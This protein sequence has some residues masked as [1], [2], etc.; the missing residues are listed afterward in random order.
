MMDRRRLVL[1]TAEV[2]RIFCVLMLAP[3]PIAFAYET[4]DLNVLGFLVP[5]NA[6]IFLATALIGALYWA[7]VRAATRGVEDQELQDREAY[8]V[9][10]IGW[11]LLTLLALIPFLWS[12]VT[13]SFGDAWFEAMSGLTT[14][15]ATILST[16]LEQVPKSIM[17]WR[18]QLEY[19][20][21]MGII[22]LSVAVL[23]R[24]T[25]GGTQLLQAEAPG[26]SVTRL[27]PKL[28]QTAKALWTVYG[29]ISALLLVI[30]TMIFLGEGLIW[31]DALYDAL[32]HTFTTVS[33]GGFSNH[34]ASIGYYDSWLLEATIILFMLIAGSN[35]TLH[36]YTLHGDWR[37]L[38]RDREWRFFMLTFIGVTLTATGMLW[39]AGQDV[40][41]GFRGAAFTVASV[42]SGTGFVAVDFNGWPEILKV[43]LLVLMITGATAGSTTG[44]LKMVRIMI[45]LKIVVREIRKL[46]HPRAV[47]PIRLGG[48]VLRDETL[49]TTVAFFFSFVTIWMVGAMLLVT[50]EPGLDVFDGA[51]IA[52]SA[53]SNFGPSMGVIGPLD[54]YGAL[55]YGSKFTMTVLM[56]A[57][58]LE[59]FT[60][61]LLFSPAAWRK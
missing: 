42:S 43:M 55:S 61:M 13:G 31:K 20:G 35:F 6:M 56:W 41:G 19:I 3:I 34:G 10:G 30:L 2:V 50:M 16:D 45:L 17:F 51:V 57:G 33:T 25:H 37:R 8:L 5:R 39:R 4:P 47:I 36:Y 40:V 14:T 59:I 18:A 1:A 44:G 11:V 52:A 12:G 49:F 9:V 15:G 60:A 54:N 58:R 32:V 24:L 38:W 27:A 48:K 22:V 23:A 26:P 21:G 28:T 53:V 29:I 7:I 46:L